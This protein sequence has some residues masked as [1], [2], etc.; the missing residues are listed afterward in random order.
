MKPIF[1]LL[2]A[3]ISAPIALNAYG[4]IASDGS[5]PGGNKFDTVEVIS[6]EPSDNTLRHRSL[7]SKRI[8][9]REELERFGDSNLSDVL[10]N[11]PGVQVTNGLPGLSGM[12][13]KYTK[14]L[15]NGD[16]APAGVSM[17][18]INPSLIE[19][20]EIVRGQSADQSSQSIGGTINIVFKDAPRT[21]KETIRFGVQYQNERP[22]PTFT[23]TIGGKAGDLSYNVPITVQEALQTYQVNSDHRIVESD[24]SVSRGYQEKYWHY[25]HTFLTISPRINYTLNDD[26]KITSQSFISMSTRKLRHHFEKTIL[27]GNPQLNNDFE[28]RTDFKIAR[29]NLAWVKNLSGTDQVE[30]KVGLSGSFTGACWLT[31]DQMIKI[32]TACEE[33]KDTVARYSANYTHLINSAHVINVGFDVDRKSQSD[34]LTENYLDHPISPL[35]YG[36]TFVGSVDTNAVF[37]QDEWAVSKSFAVNL[38]LRTERLQSTVEVPHQ[39]VSATS[40]GSSSV[41]TTNLVNPILNFSYRPNPGTKQ[42]LR[43]GFRRGY[44]APD[45]NSFGLTP[46]LQ[47]RDVTQANSAVTPDVVGNSMLK[48]EMATGVDVSY[49]TTFAKNGFVSLG[50]FYRDVNDIVIDITSLQT[51]YWSPVQ[52]WVT[53]PTNYSHGSSYGIEF[54]LRAGASDLLPDALVPAKPLSFR[55]SLNHYGSR[56]DAVSGPNNRFPTQSPWKSTIGF[57]YKPIAGLTLGGSFYM[58]PEYTTQ[59]TPSDALTQKSLRWINAFAQYSVDKKSNLRLGFNNLFPTSNATEFVTSFS[60]RRSVRSGRTSIT[61]SFDTSL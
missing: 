23:Y 13:P 24:G 41:N 39:L 36:R 4:Q 26:E 48:P 55:W 7:V 3:T 5:L 20:I 22:T 19:R 38:G 25:G 12:D 11:L 52:R 49:E 43:G 40:T 29:T 14:I 31:Q 50:A 33:V 37:V 61:L 53:Q 28:S 60:D 21:N 44:K 34:W 35:T 46:A 9:G 27:S 54:E 30:A 10:S 2:I 15:F 6:K 17:D 45:I 59:I 32:S 47:I 56:V 51:V 8:Y 42:V 1:H 18:Q 57:D 58:A 16:P